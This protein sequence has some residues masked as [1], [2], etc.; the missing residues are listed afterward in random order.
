LIQA[1]PGIIKM[2]MARAANPVIILKSVQSVED[3]CFQIAFMMFHDRAFA[4][5][6]ESRRLTMVCCFAVIFFSMALNAVA[7]TPCEKL[8]SLA[9]AQYKGTGSTKD[10]ANF[11]CRVPK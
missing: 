2:K 4:T 8:K 5:L 6:Y 3:V 9:L 7:Q 11:V 10:A 1:K